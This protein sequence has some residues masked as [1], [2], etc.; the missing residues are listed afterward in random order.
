MALVGEAHILVKAITTGVQKDIDNAFSGADSAGDK[1]G[2]KA[3]S[4][5]TRGFGNNTDGSVIFGKFYTAKEVKVFKKARQDF[6]NLART[7]YIVSVAVGVLGGAI[8]ALVGGLGVLALTVAAAAGPALLGFVGTLGA[9][10]VAAAAL[11]TVFKGVGDALSAQNDVAAGAAEREKALARATRDLEDAKYNYN[12]TVKQTEKATKD[13]A[14]AILDAADAEVDA[15]RAVESS[16]RSYQDSVEATAEALENVT[17][18]REEAKEAIQQLRFELEG[19]VISEKKARLEFEKARESLQRVQDL[20]PNSR[21]RREAELAFAEADL[22]LRRAIDKNGDLRK[23]TSQANKEG[24][25]GNKNVIASEKALIK[26]RQSQNDA[27]VAAFKATK[28][29]TKAT[30]ELNAAKEYA[31]KNGELEKKNMRDLE[32]AARAVADATQAVTDA[33]NSGGVSAYAAAMAKLSPEAQKFVEAM[34]PI[35]EEL[36]AL[37]LQMQE[38]FFKN[39]TDAVT[40]LAEVY[41]PLLTPSLVA[42]STE[43]GKVAVYFKNVFT[44]P[45]KQAE[46]KKIFDDMAIVVGNLGTAFVDFSASLVTLAAEFS[47]YMVEFSEFIKKKAAA[48]KASIEEKKASGEL[49]ET[50]DKLVDVVKKLGTAFGNTFSTL[51]NLIGAA[52]GPGSGGELLLN[53]LIDTTARW[54]KLT[55]GGSNNTGLKTF[56]LDLATNFTKLADVIGLLVIE[57]LKIGASEGFGKFLDKLKEAIPILGEVAE[58]ITAALPAFGDFVISL[59]KF[60]KL[61]VDAA[62][63]QLFFTILSTALDALVFV[64]NNPVGKAFLAITG[65]LLAASVGFNTLSNGVI[66]YK[67]SIMGSIDNIKSMKQSIDDALIV[68][69]AKS[70][71]LL[72]AAKNTKAYAVAQKIFNAVMNANPIMKIVAIILILI[73]VFIALYKNNEE[74][75]EIVDKVWNAIKETIGV[76]VDAVMGYFNKVMEIGK[77][78]WDP[79]LDGLK[80]IWGLVEGYFKLVFGFWKAIVEIFIG[81]GLIIWNFL[82]DKIIEVWA[83]V[84]G[85]WNNTVLPFITAIVGKVKEFGSAIWNWISEK[86]T[87]IWGKVTGYWDKTVYPFFSGIIK[88]VKDKAGAVWDFISDGISTAWAKVTG[89]F[90]KTLYPF[91]SG[92]KTKITSLASGMWE[93]LKGGL[94]NVVNFIIKGVNLVIK[95]INLLIRAANRVKIGKDIEEVDEIKAVNFAKGGIVFPSVGGTLARIGEAGRPER[96]EPLDPDGLSKRDKAMIQLLSGGVG[97]GINITVNPSAGMDERELAHLV[98]RQLAFQLRKGAA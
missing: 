42:I 61:V 8:G 89:F 43:L 78:I 72:T 49:K 16:E 18:A 87:E 86:L 24:V 34:K 77:A 93:G 37:K 21:A 25:N 45:E 59:A 91:I 33:K 74:V 31:K 94:E 38:A 17:K 1:A 35:K 80:F 27:E 58:K 36:A 15:K 46:V 6:L 75:R 39:F 32:L 69:K 28:D 51:G 9:V 44:T 71:A 97:G 64:L 52:I 57:I 20:P 30:Q 53:W 12:E 70:A 63:I 29:L 66:F 23:K 11:V 98:S 68:V 56:L 54:E 62:P 7:G 90:D 60:L 81:I 67:N 40:E 14:D 22:N 5:F 88:N 82:S 76:V 19:G 10:A 4:G 92:I 85:Y 48:L 65:L 55:A 83:K 84:T 95:G 3:A 47:P 13:A 79:I 50:L 73:G 41:I 96:I 26:A 2:R